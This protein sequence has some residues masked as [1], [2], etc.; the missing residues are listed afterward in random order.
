MLFRL[1]VYVVN[2]S[3]LLTYFANLF[4]QNLRAI[5][6]SEKVPFLVTYCVLSH[7]APFKLEPGGCGYSP[8]GMCI[9]I[10]LPAHFVS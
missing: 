6:P 10:M 3:L 7:E 1:G 2:N 4:Y 5:S 8:Q 9:P